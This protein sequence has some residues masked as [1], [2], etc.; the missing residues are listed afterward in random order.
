LFNLPASEVKE[1]TALLMKA[2][3]DIIA[4]TNA[5]GVNADAIVAK[6]RAAN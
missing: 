4:E 1:G 5:K 3:L 6:M 2:G